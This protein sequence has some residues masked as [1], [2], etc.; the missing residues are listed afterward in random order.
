MSIAIIKTRA[1]QGLEALEVTVEVHLSNG[2]PAFSLV[3]LPE[4]GVR[5]AK[6]RVR[7]AIINSQFDFPLKR[8]TVNLAPADLPKEGGRFDL[9]IA[10]G[11]LEA[12]GQLPQNSTE[13][14]E[15][16]GELA[17]TGE[18]RP[19][20]GALISAMACQKAGRLMILPKDNGAEAQL[21]VGDHQRV[22][23]H[24]LALTAHLHQVKKLSPAAKQPSTQAALSYLDCKDIKGQHKAKRALEIAAA[25]GHNL[26]F[27][28]PPGCGKSMLASRLPSILPPMTDEQALSQLA[29]QSI[30]TSSFN[31]QHWRQRPFRAPHHT[32]STAA[33][34][35]GGNPPRPGEV[36]LAHEGVLFLDELP[37]F[38]RNV[39]E[40][41]REPLEN[42][43]ISISRASHQAVF[44]ASFQL[45]A[46]MN[47]CP[48]GY[49]G[50]STHDCTC[51]VQQ[52]Q[53]YRKKI[54]G[55]LLDRIDIHLNL[56]PTPLVL[57]T[58]KK[59]AN[60]ETSIVVRE[61]VS[62]AFERQI[63]RQNKMNAALS[64]DEILSIGCVT[65][66]ALDCL[67]KTGEKLK[68]SARAL[69]RVCK[70]ARTLADL[71]ASE[72]VQP[73]HAFEALSYRQLASAVKRPV[74][75]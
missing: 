47:P 67:Q 5:E 2:L 14:M 22:A 48:C 42:R 20:R 28:G 33:I 51:S 46:A 66:E 58:S 61:R 65:D 4:T 69:Q 59:I 9:A 56:E 74:R 64:G 32:A 62:Q 68:L 40:A 55:P 25:G 21:A 38:Q 34:V 71:D 57:L 6:D 70:V 35:G 1:L 60:E 31:S 12:S 24:L 16:L 52:I 75:A 13:G 45:I 10:L 43:H 17:L 27:C 36:S 18:L 23:Q 11:I 50:D 54:S 63:Q 8:I 7:S 30:S 72:Q 15:F 44:P 19:V 29:I 39:L 26:L 41:L 53:R 49:H 73:K 3:G 37:E